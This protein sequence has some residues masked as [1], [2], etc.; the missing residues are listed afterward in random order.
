MKKVIILGATGSIGT[1]A[2]TA[3][4]TRKFPLRVT[5]LSCHT[6]KEKLDAL[7][8]EFRARTVLT[9]APGGFHQLK[10]MLNST[11]GDIVLNGISGFDGLRASVYTLE[12]G[13]DLALANKESVVC[14]SSFLFALARK[15]GRKIIPV[16]SEHSAIYNLLLSQKKE[17]VE[18]LVITASGGPF[19]TCSRERMAGVTVAEALHHPTWKMGP[20]ITIDSAT[21]ANKAMEVIEAAGLFGFP[22]EH[23]E[24]AIHPQSVV[25][26]LIRMKNGALYAQMG[27]PD[28]T[29]PIIGALLPG[30][31]EPL[32]QRL[33]FT[34]LSLT[35]EKP[36]LK[37]FPL[38]GLAWDILRDGGA[39]ALAFNASDEVAVHAFLSGTI[40]FLGIERV[41]R[42]V[43]ENCVF[44][45][46]KSLAE[47]IEIDHIMRE[48]AQAECGRLS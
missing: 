25:H 6:Q 48:K 36:D 26:S 10:E 17:E 2:L 29:L 27:M 32:V 33:D 28:M 35:F 45:A 9:G 39:K 47:A 5:A 43:T 37:R 14:G 44:P 22:P 23:I 1:T 19:R 4:R 7:G 16:D 42:A 12:S 31:T 13:R 8:K 21:L 34:S 41:V 30:I 15:N 11:E 18:N 3:I 38:L 24:V 20:K 40:P 46:P